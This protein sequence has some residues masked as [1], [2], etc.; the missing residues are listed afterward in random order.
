MPGGQ[1]ERKTLWRY[2]EHYQV[3]N[4]QFR[5]EGSE[6]SCLQQQ[7]TAPR[8]NCG[9]PMPALA[10]RATEA[11]HMKTSAFSLYTPNILL[12]FNFLKLKANKTVENLHILVPCLQS[13]NKSLRFVTVSS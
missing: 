7:Q 4:M 11:F 6:P 5:T 9:F 13:Q 12:E 3:F 1:K 10:V 8:W 2:R